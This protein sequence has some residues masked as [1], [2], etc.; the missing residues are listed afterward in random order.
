MRRYY[1]WVKQRLIQASYWRLGWQ[2]V[3]PGAFA[4]LFLAKSLRAHQPGW[5]ILFAV[6][7]VGA[8]VQVV[9]GIL[10]KQ[11]AKQDQSN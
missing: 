9:A 10:F 5:A 8:V 4:A 6:L 7:M 2:L 11:Q 1:T 3:F